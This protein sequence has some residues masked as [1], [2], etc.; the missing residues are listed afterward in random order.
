MQVVPFPFAALLQRVEA[1]MGRD[2][3]APATKAVLIPLGRS[4]QRNSAAP[5]FFAYP[6]AVVAVD[7]EPAGSGDLVPQGPA[8]SRLS[9]KG[10]PARGHQ[11]Q[12]GRGAIRVPGGH[13]LSCRAAR[14]G[15]T[16]PT[17]RCASPATRMP[18]RYFPA[19]SGTR[20]MRIRA[21]RRCWRRSAGISTAFRSIAASTCRMPSTM[22]RCAPTGSRSSNCSGK[23]DAAAT[24][25]RP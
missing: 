11:L 4:L 2:S 14:P 3:R 19:P 12:R 10:E 21:W 20:P 15:S 5:D 24:T 22:R 1:R 6:R 7:A 13:R 25:S 16:T 9:G 18:P 23:T 17:G 8:L